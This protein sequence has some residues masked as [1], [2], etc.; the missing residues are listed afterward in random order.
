M[1][2]LTQLRLV[3]TRSAG[4][5]KLSVRFAVSFL[6]KEWSVPIYGVTGYIPQSTDIIPAQT[7]QHGFSRMT[8]SS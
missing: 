1:S 4:Q 7:F 5:A 8:I 2:S 6:F 3:D